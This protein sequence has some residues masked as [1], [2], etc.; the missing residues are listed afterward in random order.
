MKVTPLDLRQQRFR[1]AF[2]GFDRA[3]VTTL[4][5]E[6]ADQYES[7][8]LE[9]ERLRQEAMHTEASLNEHR[10]HERNLK[11]TLLMAQKL[12]EDIKATAE[13]QAD[14]IIREAEGRSDLLLQKSHTR[15]ED[16]QRE[17]DGLRMKRRDVEAS[18]EATIASLRNAVAFVHEQDQRDRDDKILLHRPRPA[19]I[20]TPPAPLS[21]PAQI[22]KMIEQLL[23]MGA[24]S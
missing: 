2:R 9:V 5:H 15:L 6:V 19:D 20:V 18:I 1:P 7:A 8:L 21:G 23:E 17:I 3:E 12:A 14:A 11:N 22:P 13:R 10:E 16:L 24:K 4:L